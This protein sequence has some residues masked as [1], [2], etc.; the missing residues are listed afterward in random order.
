MKN[1]EELLEGFIMLMQASAGV[2]RVLL[3]EDRQLDIPSDQI[4]NTMN[5]IFA[6][7]TPRSYRS[8]NWMTIFIDCG[9]VRYLMRDYRR[10][11][12]GDDHFMSFLQKPIAED[13]SEQVSE[14][15]EDF[16]KKV[17][18][19]FSEVLEYLLE[20]YTTSNELAYTLVKQ[21]G[22]M[23]YGYKK[24]YG[25]ELITEADFQE[26]RKRSL[27]GDTEEL[28]QMVNDLKPVRDALKNHL[29]WAA[30]YDELE[31]TLIFE[32]AWSKSTLV[33]DLLE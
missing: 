8:H 12:R 21:S 11:K 26:A 24:A 7:E 32:S 29:R 9:Y 33:V 15:L 16:K 25:E 10:W 23:R 17:F 14:L 3:A 30:A 13:K 5:P 19:R 18:I 28:F 20:N 1:N 31:A 27:F 6:L 2:F 22:S 4:M